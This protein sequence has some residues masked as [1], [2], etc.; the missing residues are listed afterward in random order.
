MPTTKRVSK[1]KRTKTEKKTKSASRKTA[2]KKATIKK[3]ISK[4]VMKTI[5]QAIEPS[6]AIKII[7]IMLILLGYAM[8]RFYPIAT[9]NGQVISRLRYYQI[10]EAQMG[11]TTLSNLVTEALI[12][13]AAKQQN[14][15]ISQQVIDDK[16][17]SIEAQIKSQGMDL[18]EALS[19][20]GLTKADLDREIMLQQIV[21]TLGQG[22]VDVTDAQIDAFLA[23]NKDSAPEGITAS[24][25]RE[26][27]KTQL[28]SQAQKTNISNWLTDLKDKATI[29]YR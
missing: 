4:S 12:M 5:P 20:E 11:K 24:A 22:T 19:Q 29:I 9:V 26:M 7:A 13:D 21:E 25:L 3:P 2:V 6:L 1:N 23:E 27:A 16:V 28:E 10:M 15:V 14:L 17:A 8:Y 18:T